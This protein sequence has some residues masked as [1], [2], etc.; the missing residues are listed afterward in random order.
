[1]RYSEISQLSAASDAFHLHPR[2]AEFIEGEEKNQYNSHTDK[3][4]RAT[5]SINSLPLNNAGNLN[6]AK[7]KIPSLAGNPL[8]PLQPRPGQ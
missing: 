8:T 4:K 5:R 7:K 1:M 6:E 2:E 3:L